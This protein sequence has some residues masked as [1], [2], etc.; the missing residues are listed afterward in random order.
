MSVNIWR[1][2]RT[3]DAWRLQHI[4]WNFTQDERFKVLFRGFLS[5]SPSSFLL[6]LKTDVYVCKIS[7]EFY[8]TVMGLSNFIRSKNMLW[9]ETSLCT[10]KKYTNLENT[11]NL[12]LNKNIFKMVRR[13]VIFYFLFYFKCR[14][15]FTYPVYEV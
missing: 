9:N 2:H 1:A 11:N 15:I 12:K 3:H 7:T 10:N 4:R 5:P 8:K 13:Q 6:P 14:Y